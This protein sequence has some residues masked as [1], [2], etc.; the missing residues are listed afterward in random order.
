MK[1]YMDGT[2]IVG[3]NETNNGARETFFEVAKE[4]EKRQTILA[5]VPTRI[6]AHKIAVTERRNSLEHIRKRKN[7]YKDVPAVCRVVQVNRYGVHDGFGMTKTLDVKVNTKE[8][9]EM[10]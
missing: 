6:E 3:M 2:S 8:I 4:S 10:S 1:Y 5:R 7:K 9:I